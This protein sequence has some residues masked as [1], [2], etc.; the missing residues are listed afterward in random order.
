MIL[1]C[2]EGGS[3]GPLREILPDLYSLLLPDPENMT[4]PI[5]IQ[6]LKMDGTG[7]KEQEKEARRGKGGR[8]EGNI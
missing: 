3:L 2:F 1:I 8:G 5:H 7:E 4:D 6:Q